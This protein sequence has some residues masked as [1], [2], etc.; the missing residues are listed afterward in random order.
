M[1][2]WQNIAEQALRYWQEF[3]NWFLAIPLYGQVLVIFGAAIIL[4]LV[5]VLVYYVLKGV[6]YLVYYLLKSV[7]LLLK[8]I[9]ILF[10]KLF[11]AIYYA[12]SGKPRPPKKESMQQE[13]IQQ[14]SSQVQEE[15]M[16]IEPKE[17]HVIQPHAAYCSE[18]GAEFTEKMEQQLLENGIVFCVH[19]GKGYK[20]NMIEIEQ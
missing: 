14:N 20:A 13:P 11:E 6:V 18:C 16:H 9:G 10:Y 5:I 7:Y 12:I 2:N 19:C 3:L 4:I 15:Q 1:V 8:G 17:I